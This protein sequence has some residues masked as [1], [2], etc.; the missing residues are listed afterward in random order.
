MH[1]GASRGGLLTPFAVVADALSHDRC[2][3]C[4]RTANAYR[5]VQCTV[6]R[7]VSSDCGSRVSA[8]SA[9][10]RR[11]LRNAGAHC[12]SRSVTDSA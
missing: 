2:R 5:A 11:G 10:R 9:P 4:C 6:C 8:V 1:L 7:G 12:T 3:Y